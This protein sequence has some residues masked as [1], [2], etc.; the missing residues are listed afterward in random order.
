M[1]LGILFEY[2]RAVRERQSEGEEDLPFGLHPA[3]LARLDPIDGGLGDP[4][5]P[6]ELGFA[7]E[8]SFPK[9]LYAV[10]R[11][12]PKPPRLPTSGQAADR[13]D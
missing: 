13:D 4:R 12:P 7:E 3:T 2:F 8:L 10:H 1:V 11:I 5:T 9:S 6:C